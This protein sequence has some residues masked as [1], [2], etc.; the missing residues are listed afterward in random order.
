MGKTKQLVAIV[1]PLSDR[2]QL[3]TDELISLRH[4]VHYLGDYPKY[5]VGSEATG[6]EIPGFEMK[7]FSPRYF[8][9]ADAY[10]RL[11]LSRQ[12]YTSFAAYEYILIY[13]LDAL[14][15][16][17]QLRE[18]CAA[19]FDY[20]GA[21][22]LRSPDDPTQGFSR[23]GNS[24]FSLRS[25]SAALRVIDSRR[26]RIHPDEYWDKAHAAKSW[27]LR[28]LNRPRKWAKH[29]TRLNGARWEMSR[30]RANDDGFWSNRAQHY[31]PDFR[32]PS[33]ET[34]LRFAFECA[35]RYCYEQN[36]RQLPFGCHAW[37]RYDRAFW[38]PFL[39]SEADA[40][41]ALTLS[42]PSRAVAADAT[43]RE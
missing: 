30:Y 22:W 16:S 14:V 12:F 28:L 33:V 35:P 36:G 5:L 31:C 11:V 18:W 41:A 24:G 26:Y 3:T 27:P 19:G 29:V 10:K 39:L 7:R 32:I 43:V 4:L 20:L 17:D 37:A 38:E 34:A 21:P 13:H 1:V 8:G 42:A 2:P 6:I 40:S 23:V 15:F 25:V 9:S